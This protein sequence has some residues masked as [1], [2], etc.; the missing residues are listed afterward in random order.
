MIS[1]GAGW[2]EHNL[3]EKADALNKAGFTDALVRV[4][5]NAPLGSNTAADRQSLITSQRILA[6]MV[7]GKNGLS[8]MTD[9]AVGAQVRQ[10][11]IGV[12]GTTDG[13]ATAIVD[14]DHL[15]F[16]VQSVGGYYAYDPVTDSY[17]AISQPVY[18]ASSLEYAVNTRLTYVKIS[19]LKIVEIPISYAYPVQLGAGSLSV[20]GSLKF[21]SG[22]THNARIKVDT[23]SANIDDQLGGSAKDSN[24]VSID[25]GLL[26]IP[27]RM[28]NLT[29]G[30]V[31]KNLTS[32]SFDT[33]VAG[34]SYK[35]KPQF[36]GGVNLAV[37]SNFD[38]ALDYDLSRNETFIR[39]LDT[40]YIGGGFNFRPASWFSVR[41]GAMKNLASSEEGTVLTGGLGFGLKWFQ[42]MMAVQMSNKKGQLDGEDIPRYARANISLVSSW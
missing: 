41:L 17:S 42:L 1:A 40:Q 20:G 35:V 23:A 34:E 3:A 16:S 37:S 14:P 7:G 28:P 32:P 38:I 31:G 15:A 24:A 4:A 30:L 2:R 22:T 9:A 13:T 11:G 39:D 10:V 36:R 21:M 26:F 25:A 29:L 27:N 33:V 18:E 6:S 8:M 19:G 5:Q 12:Y